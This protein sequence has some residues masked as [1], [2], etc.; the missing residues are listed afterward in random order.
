MNKILKNNV[1]NVIKYITKLDPKT[2]ITVLAI[3]SAAY[4]ICGSASMLA[5]KA[6]AAGYDM[7]LNIPGI[8]TLNMKKSKYAIND[9]AFVTA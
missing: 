5:D 8:I 9:Q 7:E 4:L 1:G 2:G 3:G 6:I